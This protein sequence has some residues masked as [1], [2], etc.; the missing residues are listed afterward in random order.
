MDKLTGMIVIFT[1]LAVISACQS[2][3]PSPTLPPTFGPRGFSSPPTILAYIADV[4]LDQT[5]RIEFVNPVTHECHRNLKSE[6]IT[7]QK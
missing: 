7:L 6:P 1:W 4:Q 3:Q 5:T 2:A